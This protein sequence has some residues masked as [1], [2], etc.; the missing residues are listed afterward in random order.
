[1]SFNKSG[2]CKPIN[3]FRYKWLNSPIL[4]DPTIV[5]FL[6]N[7]DKLYE[8]ERCSLS[9]SSFCEM[10]VYPSVKLNFG[11]IPLNETPTFSTWLHEKSII[12]I[13]VVVRVMIILILFI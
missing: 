5:N 2:V 6:K 9:L 7:L 3:K 11:N 8:I 4:Q 10:Y 12:R 13:G 1:M